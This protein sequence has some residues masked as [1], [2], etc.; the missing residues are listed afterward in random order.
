LLKRHV[1][2]VSPAGWWTAIG[3]P[4]AEQSGLIGLLGRCVLDQA[5]REARA[6]LDMGYWLPVA[7]NL[8]MRDM[9]DPDLP[10]YIERI[11]AKW[12][13][14]A[15][16][17]R[18]EI[19]ESSLML[20]PV[21]S[22]ATVMRLREL[23][24]RLSVDDYGTGYSSL[25]YLQQLPVDELKI[26]RS[27]IRHMVSNESD[28][29]IVRSTVDLAHGLGLS[30]V[31]EGGGARWDMAPPGSHRLRPGP[32]IPPLR[33]AASRALHRVAARLQRATL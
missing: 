11:L 29:M 30:V 1:S 31:A 21:R 33:S 23:G 20:D 16:C 10:E 7:V 6:W 26:D 12:L 5:V 32:G 24:V 2:S 19:T 8:S 25:R 17:L 13:M 9:L 14:D 4:I 27:F 15:S 3:I 28:L 18:V 22:R